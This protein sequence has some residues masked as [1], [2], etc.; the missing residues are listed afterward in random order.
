M[1]FPSPALDYQECRPS[2]DE[3][4]RTREP[5]VFIVVMDSEAMQPTIHKDDLMVIDRA[6]TARHGQIVI[7][8]INGEHMCRRFNQVNGEVALAPDNPTY[9]PRYVLPGDELEVWGVVI[10]SVRRHEN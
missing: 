2:I 1:S 5:S 10:G 3:L 4:L 6:L 8:I 9:K 7:G